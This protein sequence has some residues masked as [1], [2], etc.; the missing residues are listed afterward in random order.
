LQFVRENCI[1]DTI[2]Q[3]VGEH[4][5]DDK[6]LQLVG[7][8]CTADTI[9]QLDGEHGYALLTQLCYH[10]SEYCLLIT[11]IQFGALFS[12]TCEKTRIYTNNISIKSRSL[13]FQIIIFLHFFRPII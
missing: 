11:S 10:T 7:E 1:A 5:I 3:L 12:K 13:I 2:L 4:Y 9:L 8:N 6:I